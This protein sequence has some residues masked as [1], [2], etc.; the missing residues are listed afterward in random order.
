MTK[1]VKLVAVGNSTG[2]IIP[3]DVLAR[4]RIDRGDALSLSE[5]PDG[6]QL[7]IGNPEFDAQMVVARG[8]MKRR[9]TA[10]AELAK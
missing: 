5:T 9:R 4:L 10:L 1:P 7:R 8:V 2:I 3:K 6:F